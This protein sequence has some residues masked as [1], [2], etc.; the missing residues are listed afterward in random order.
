MTSLDS[1]V[2][3]VAERVRFEREA[4]S[5][6]RGAEHAD[7]ERVAKGSPDPLQATDRYRLAMPYADRL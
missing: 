4:P 2:R 6:G 1:D 7:P 3:V 5:P